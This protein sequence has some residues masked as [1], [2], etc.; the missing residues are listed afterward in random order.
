MGDSRD[1][2]FHAK[3]AIPYHEHARV[4]MSEKDSS[5]PPQNPGMF[6]RVEKSLTSANLFGALSQGPAAAQPAPA[7]PAPQPAPAPNDKQ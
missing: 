7:Q 6:E 3:L 2:P 4:K 1:F 5:P